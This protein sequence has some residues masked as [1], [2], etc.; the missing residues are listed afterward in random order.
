MRLVEKYGRDSG[1]IDWSSVAKELSGGRDMTY[2]RKTYNNY[3]RT[4]ADILIRGRFSAEDDA[5]ITRRVLGVDGPFQGWV[6][7]GKEL[8]GRLSSS[9]VNHWALMQRRNPTLGDSACVSSVSAA[10]SAAVETRPG[11]KRWTT[12]EV[13]VMICY[14]NLTN[15]ICYCNFINLN[16]MSNMQLILIESTVCI[17]F[18]PR[19]PC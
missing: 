7:L 17:I 4:D 10:E 8:G 2:L 5:I 13:T 19:M 12:E 18:M 6:A 1:C 3:R 11:G 16:M 9:V 14:C 15:L